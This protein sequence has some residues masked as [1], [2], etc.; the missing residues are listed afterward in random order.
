MVML[1]YSKKMYLLNVKEVW[2]GLIILVLAVLPQLMYNYVNFD[3]ILATGYTSDVNINRYYVHPKYP[4]PLTSW[5]IFLKV[6]P[7]ARN[8]YF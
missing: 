2:L 8:G 6:S 4:G 1:F 3:S 7:G 5:N